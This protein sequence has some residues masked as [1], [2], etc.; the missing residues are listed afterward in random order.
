MYAAKYFDTSEA[1]AH[2]WLDT[3]L[4]SDDDCAVLQSRQVRR[5]RDH[6]RQ[7]VPHQEVNPVLCRLLPGNQALPRVLEVM[8]TYSRSSSPRY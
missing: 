4:P 1:E 7:D 3:Y 2:L 8:R 6:D 5:E